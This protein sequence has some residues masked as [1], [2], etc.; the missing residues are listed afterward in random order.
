MALLNSQVLRS[1][2]GRA[3]LLP[4]QQAS[5]PALPR[6]SSNALIAG[7]QVAVHSCQNGGPCACSGAGCLDQ[8]GASV[9]SVAPP[10]LLSATQVSLPRDALAAAT[11]ASGPADFGG[12]TELLARQASFFA[13]LFRD[14]KLTNVFRQSTWMLEQ[15]RRLDQGVLARAELLARSPSAIGLSSPSTSQMSLC[16]C[17]TGE[18]T[19]VVLVLLLI[20]N[21]YLVKPGDSQSVKEEKKKREA[22]FL[23]NST[24]IVNGLFQKFCQS[25]PPTFDKAMAPYPICNLCGNGEPCGSCDCPAGWSEFPTFKCID[26]K[27]YD[28]Q[29]CEGF[30][31]DIMYKAAS[32]MPGGLSDAATFVV[33][34]KF[35][36]KYN[37]VC[38]GGVGLFQQGD[39]VTF[40]GAKSAALWLIGQCKSVCLVSILVNGKW[41]P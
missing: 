9:R 7:Q 27:C 15:F 31:Y 30:V 13:R 18:L 11:K 10:T 24:A 2:R 23:A 26:A 38:Q 5:A 36:L 28:T 6:G 33:N 39:G 21:S 32:E 22:H 25:G 19:F 8:S 17:S 29:T 4:M 40:T 12:L 1:S 37:G 14:S 35:R 3:A 41:Y 34:F 20:V 16:S